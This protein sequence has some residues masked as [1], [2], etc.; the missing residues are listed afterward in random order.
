MLETV[1]GVGVGAG[2]RFSERGA[3]ELGLKDNNGYIIRENMLHDS[4][5]LDSFYLL[6]IKASDCFS[7]TL[8]PL[9]AHF[10][11]CHL[12]HVCTHG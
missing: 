10:L 5:N 4:S 1:R 3:S 7:F 2:S 6:P 11:M 8:S 12:R 9:C